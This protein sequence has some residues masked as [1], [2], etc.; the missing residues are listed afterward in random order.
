[1][2]KLIFKQT[3]GIYCQEGYYLLP[4]LTVP[5]IGSVGIWG[6]RHLPQDFLHQFA[7]EWQAG[8]LSGGH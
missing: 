5:E 1:M 6:Q 3:G 8:Q 2:E 4:N 7:V